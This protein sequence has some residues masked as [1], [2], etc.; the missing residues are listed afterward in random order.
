MCYWKLHAFV[1]IWLLNSIPKLLYW[2][3]VKFAFYDG[4]IEQWWNR[5]ICQITVLKSYCPLSQY[6]VYFILLSKCIFL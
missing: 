1:H 5:D 6:F 4:W 3:W 2:T